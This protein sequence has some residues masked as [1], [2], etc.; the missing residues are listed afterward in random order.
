MAETASQMTIRSTVKRWLRQHATPV[1]IA[2]MIEAAE[3][4]HALG[5]EINKHDLNMLRSL[6]QGG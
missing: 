1:A 5:G 2:S 4:T 6:L 3:N